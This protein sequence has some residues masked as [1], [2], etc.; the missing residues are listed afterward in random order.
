MENIKKFYEDKYKD[1]EL[2]RFDNYPRNLLLAKVL[3]K[4]MKPEGRALDLA[5]NDG[6][7]AKYLEDQGLDVTGMDISDHALDAARSRGL[8][9][10]YQGDVQEAL[11]FADSGFDLVWWGDNVEHLFEPMKTLREI[12]RVLD[13]EG[14]LLLS[15]PNMGWIYCRIEYLITGS[16]R[17]TESMDA[18][19][20]QWDH[21]RFFNRNTIE[22]FINGG[23][24]EMVGFWGTGERPSHVIP[25]RFWPSMF[26]KLMLV[27]ARKKK[28]IG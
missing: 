24:F 18:P 21:I 12:H 23:G 9:K 3:G 5:C 1:K 17:R 6:V 11:P 16:I 10:L 26:G 2:E 25:A 20:W 19:P 8:K 28:D 22:A 4:Y 13:D 27:A 14:Y 7:V 15:A